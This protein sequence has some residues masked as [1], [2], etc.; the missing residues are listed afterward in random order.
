MGQQSATKTFIYQH[1]NK[2]QNKVLNKLRGDSFWAVKIKGKRR[3]I[4]RKLLSETHMCLIL[5]SEKSRV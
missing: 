3:R 2:D 4:G 5:I 1:G